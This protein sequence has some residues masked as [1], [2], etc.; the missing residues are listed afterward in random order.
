MRQ[1][2]QYSLSINKFSNYINRSDEGI[3]LERSAIIHTFV[4]LLQFRNY[5]NDVH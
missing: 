4:S 3:S 5:K 1:I 2:E